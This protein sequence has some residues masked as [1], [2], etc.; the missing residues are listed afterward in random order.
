M[1]QDITL[2]ELLERQHSENHT[3]IDVRSPQ[4]YNET[5]IPGSI[6][7]PVFS[8]DER[9]EV[10]TLYKQV[11]KEAAKARGLEIMSAKLPDFIAKFREIDTPKTVFC[12]RGGMR[13]KTAATL[14]DLMG[15]DVN[16]LQGGVRAYRQWIVS[17]LETA[18]FPPDIIVLNGNTG[19][20]KTKL[21]HQ[22]AEN[23]YPIIDLEG[24]AGHRG[25][26][27]G[28]IGLEPTIQKEFESQLVQAMHM[29][30]DAP[31]VLMEGESKRIGKVTMPEFLFKKKEQSM[32]LFIDLPVEQRI[33]N[34]LDDYQPWNHPDQFV[35]AFERIQKRIHTPVAKQIHE[36]LKEENYKQAIHL[37]LDYYYDPRYEHMAGKYPPDK[38]KTINAADM[39]DAAE[40]I[41]DVLSDMYPQRT[42]SLKDA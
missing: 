38:T 13:S 17:E 21:L 31:F 15:L 28:H 40:R 18:D 39:K 29:F 19:T 3:I 4:E 14:V 1:F 16:R 7:I 34:I 2:K 8:N 24:M 26:I 25:S 23:G 32:Q 36:D 22:L 11:G 12:W 10:G 30:H 35:E 6:N 20:G 42:K 27:F 5:T 33:L 9:A 37:L 41:E